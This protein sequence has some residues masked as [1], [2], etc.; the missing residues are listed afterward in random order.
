MFCC[1][2]QSVR[3]AC[4]V[5]CRCHAWAPWGFPRRL[6]RHIEGL[7]WLILVL[8]Q[9]FFLLGLALAEVVGDDYIPCLFKGIRCTLQGMY[10]EDVVV[11]FR[12]IYADLQD[13]G[14]LPKDRLQFW[15]CQFLTDLDSR[16]WFSRYTLLL[17]LS[18]WVVPPCLKNIDDSKSSRPAGAW[19]APWARELLVES[20]T[21]FFCLLW[22]LITW[23]D[24]ERAASRHYFASKYVM[25]RD[26]YTREA[27]LATARN[28]VRNPYAAFPL[29]N[30]RM[31]NFSPWR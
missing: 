8:C 15:A 13:V 16:F 24:V 3:L 2:L 14:T 27:Q 6:Y 11:E 22:F 30:L 28:L 7:F 9:V 18:S 4:L 17:S 21:K 20:I 12:G 19:S 5:Q 26:L 29:M 10:R 23:P 25:Y 1:A 31:K